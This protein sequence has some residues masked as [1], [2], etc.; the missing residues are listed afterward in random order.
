MDRSVGVVADEHLVGVHEVEDPERFDVDPP[1]LGIGSRPVQHTD[2]GTALV[3]SA[4]ELIN[5]D[6]AD[7]AER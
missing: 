7:A 5:R 1:D 3:Q 2:P 4:F 6:D